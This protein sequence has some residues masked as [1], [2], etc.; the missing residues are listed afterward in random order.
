MIVLHGS[1][2]SPNIKVGDIVTDFDQT[3]VTNLIITNTLPPVR[4]VEVMNPGTNTQFRVSPAMT[5]AGGG[6]RLPTGATIDFTRSS[7]KNSN[8]QY[9]SN[10]SI[11]TIDNASFGGNTNGSY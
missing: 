9:V 1:S 11:Q 6:T 8:S 4:V 2:A 7:M 5:I 10:Y 3:D